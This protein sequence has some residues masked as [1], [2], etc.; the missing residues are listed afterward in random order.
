M[1]KR[2]EFRYETLMGM[3]MYVKLGIWKPNSH[4]DTPPTKEEII[5][6]FQ[7]AFLLTL[8]KEA[9][10]SF[11]FNPNGSIAS[12]DVREDPNGLNYEVECTRNSLTCLLE[13]LWGSIG[14]E[15]LCLDIEGMGIHH[16]YFRYL[17]ESGDRYVA[18]ADILNGSAP[19]APNVRRFITMLCARPFTYQA[20][21]EDERGIGLLDYPEELRRQTILDAFR[22]G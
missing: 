12:I 8:A 13:G 2:T 4:V 22:L 6:I 3:A 17:P 14:G 21:L 19:N 1:A 16:D 7:R 18:V 11:G 20:H 15:N 5:A 9:S 10:G